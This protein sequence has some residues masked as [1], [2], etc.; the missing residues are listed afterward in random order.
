M[1]L[2]QI[3]VF[4]A[5]YS[6]GSMTNAAKLLNVSQPSVSKVLAHAEQQLG[7]RLFD[8]VKGKLIATPEA[9]RLF[10]L[11]SNVFDHVEQLR[12]VA[13]NLRASDVG[14]VRIAA[15]PAFGVDLLPAAVSGYL[16]EHSDTV[17]EIE[18]LHHDEIA[19]ALLS[20]RIDIG[21]VFDTTPVPG[22]VSE[23]LANDEFVVIAPQNTDLGGNDRVS[24]DELAGLPFIGLS[25]R[26]P[27]G[28]LLTSHLEKSGVDLNMIVFTETYQIAKALVAKGSGVSI[29]DAITACA[30]ERDNV[31]RW[32]LDP[33]LRY[34]I[35]VLHADSMPPSILCRRF[36]KHLKSVIG[37][38]LH[39]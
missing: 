5:I 37:Q 38:H 14:K 34:S 29:V 30:T 4:H 20:S 39:H 24:I 10:G 27:L 13:E 15:T 16:E 32:L 2:R 35:D 3:E 7:Y 21:L 26:G 31:R 25:G 8:R 19:G 11:V 23:T 12:H 36:V 17:F 33:P 22:L 9:D 1:R 28:R 18:T 6:S